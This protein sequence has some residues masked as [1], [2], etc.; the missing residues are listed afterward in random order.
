MVSGTLTGSSGEIERIVM[1]V[2]EGHRASVAL[3]DWV[4]LIISPLLGFGGSE[5]VS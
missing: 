1:K 2:E 3:M 5:D 4:R